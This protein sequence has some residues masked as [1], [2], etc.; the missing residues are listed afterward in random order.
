M[1]CVVALAP[2]GLSTTKGP[3]VN[4]VEEAEVYSARFKGV[5]HDHAIVKK[6]AFKFSCHYR[7]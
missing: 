5:R 1:M 2:V 4:K 6:N 3:N 7:N